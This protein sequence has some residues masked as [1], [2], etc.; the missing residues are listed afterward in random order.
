MEGG[1][2]FK[3]TLLPFKSHLYYNADTFVV[4][5]AVCFFHKAELVDSNIAKLCWRCKGLTHE[6]FLCT[7]SPLMG[8]H[9]CRIREESLVFILE[10]QVL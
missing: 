3:N 1:A 9:Y 5:P 10:V 8:Q 6:A 4:P 7:L 2:F